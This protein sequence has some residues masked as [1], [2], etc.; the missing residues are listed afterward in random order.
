MPIVRDQWVISHIVAQTH[1]AG[2]TQAAS[3]T[4]PLCETRSLLL[5][6]IA[7]H[8]GNRQDALRES[9]S[10]VVRR[11]RQQQFMLARLRAIG[12]EPLCLSTGVLEHNPLGLQEPSH[13]RPK[14]VPG[15]VPCDAPE[16]P[17]Q[18]GNAILLAPEV[19]ESG[20]S[21]PWIVNV[22]ATFFAGVTFDLKQHAYM[23][24]RWPGHYNTLRFRT[25][26]TKMLSDARP[27]PCTPSC[28][29]YNNGLVSITNT[30]SPHQ[31]L[32]NAHVY[33]RAL[34]RAG[35]LDARVLNFKVDNIV[36]A[37]DFGFRVRLQCMVRSI[38]DPNVMHY[39]PEAFPAAIYRE[40]ALGATDGYSPPSDARV[41][42][43]IFASGKVICVGFRSMEQLIDVHIKINRI[44]RS[45]VCDANDL[46][47][48]AGGMSDAHQMQQMN[49]V[50]QL[51]YEMICMNAPDKAV[52]L[53]T[54]P[55]IAPS[56]GSSL[57]PQI[58]NDIAVN[59]VGTDDLALQA[60]SFSELFESQA[61]V[62]RDRV[63]AAD[64]QS[65][66]VMP[67]V[68]QLTHAG[69]RAL[70]QAIDAMGERGMRAIGGDG[71]FGLSSNALL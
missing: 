68:G 9:A 58:G 48:A 43:L 12:P 62:E 46:A 24:P 30:R 10:Q 15:A 44:A 63:F 35:I 38:A 70:H 40:K 39:D 50:D 3:T 64:Q 20:I 66:N 6:Q 71:L 61:S 31:A 33:V 32:L 53:L 5:R 26:T 19:R 23:N 28:K 21:M 18:F 45:F 25:L 22:T 59:V 14:S 41:A 57:F 47:N 51:M 16:D 52:A 34:Q 36:A 60:T 27:T 54:Q 49:D 8:C 17:L 55:A 11:K 13:Q 29:V 56:G 42:V 37:S 1:M 4:H 67:L 65:S 69:V 7:R 2:S